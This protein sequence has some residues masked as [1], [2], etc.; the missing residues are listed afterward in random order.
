[1]P[2]LGSASMTGSKNAR[3]RPDDDHLV[4]QV[5]GDAA[6]AVGLRAL[7]AHRLDDQRRVERLVGDLG[8]VGPGLLRHRRGVPHAALVEPVGEP[9]QRP[10]REPDGG[11]ER[12]GHDQQ[13][14]GDDQHDRRAERHRQ[15]RGDE[16]GR[17]DVRVG[18]GQQLA[19]GCRRC[20]EMGSSR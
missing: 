8:D 3:R 6:E 1:M 4:A 20:H 7:P 16:E 12:V 19:G 10:D 17:L 11:Q 15:R 2:T 5:V 18:V 13:R 9:E 14:R